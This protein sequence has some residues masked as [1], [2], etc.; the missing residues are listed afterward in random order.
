MRGGL[1]GLGAAT[2]SMAV[3]KKGRLDETMLASSAAYNHFL[4]RRPAS[5]EMR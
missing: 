2:Q 4:V 3:P 1:Y 5:V